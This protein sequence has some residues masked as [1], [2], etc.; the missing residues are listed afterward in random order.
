MPKQEIEHDMRQAITSLVDAKDPATKGRLMRRIIDGML[1]RGQ[2]EVELIDLVFC[3][4]DP[5]R[6]ATRAEISAYLTEH[7]GEWTPAR[8]DDLRKAIAS[9]RSLPRSIFRDGF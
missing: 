1:V 5:R 7:P 8:D 2:N 3:L 6:Q 4:D 9:D